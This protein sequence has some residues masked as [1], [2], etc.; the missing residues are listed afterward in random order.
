[1]NSTTKKLAGASLLAL[2]VTGLGF[3]SAA[4][5]NADPI[6]APA[7]DAYIGSQDTMLSVDAASGVFAN[8]E[9]NGGVPTIGSIAN[10]VNGELDLHVDG[11]FDYTPAAGFIGQRTFDYEL[12]CDGVSAGFATAAIVFGPTVPVGA[13]DSYSTPQDTTLTIPANGVLANDTGALAVIDAKDLPEGLTP[14]FDGSFVYAPPA[15]FVGDVSWSYRM[16]DGTDT[17]SDWILVTISVTPVA[18]TMIPTDA[19]AQL[20]TLAYTGGSDVTTWLLGPA[21]AFLGL[22][23]AAALVARRRARVS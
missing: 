22:G 13:A 3:T 23:A 17:F 18:Q 9:C 8:D 10:F 2:T 19:D 11:S 12:L 15:G 14:Q 7:A 5:A 4:A 1:M 21:F 16:S 20:P 6:P